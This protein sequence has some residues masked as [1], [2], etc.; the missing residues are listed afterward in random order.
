[1]SSYS[2]FVKY[3]AIKRPERTSERKTNRQ[4]NPK[5]FLSAHRAGT[6]MAR[7]PVGGYPCV[8][9]LCQGG[10]SAGT[11]PHRPRHR[12]PP[13][14]ANVC[15]QVVCWLRD[16]ALGRNWVSSSS[17]CDFF[18][19]VYWR[20]TNLEAK[21]NGKFLRMFWSMHKYTKHH[22]FLDAL[23][24]KEQCLITRANYQ[25]GLWTRNVTWITSWKQECQCF[26]I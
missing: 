9:A 7:V 23:V 24:N 20:I 12:S 22:T 6:L 17:H 8:A 14:T 19:S 26:F 5:T 18:L 4:I 15:L 25:T 16:R 1:M 21:N 11:A 2:V 13:E 3:F 10:G